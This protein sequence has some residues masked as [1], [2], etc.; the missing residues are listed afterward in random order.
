[1]AVLRGAAS[2]GISVP[3]DVSVTGFDGVAES[4][5]SVPPLTTAVQPVKEVGA[6]AARLL[7]EGGPPR[8]VTLP[9]ELVI[10]ESTG[11]PR[12]V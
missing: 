12:L 8:H 6:T 4:A 9:V 2:R 7:L 3:R 10:R 11:N 5:T 1:M